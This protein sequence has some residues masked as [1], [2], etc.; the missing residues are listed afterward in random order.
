MV[1]AVEPVT[2]PDRAPEPEVPVPDDPEDPE[3]PDV[4]VLPVPEVPAAAAAGALFV[5][6][7]DELRWISQQVHPG[8][9]QNSREFCP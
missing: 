5:V 6:R 7:L 9:G 2:V 3:V 1:S 4:P 8:Y